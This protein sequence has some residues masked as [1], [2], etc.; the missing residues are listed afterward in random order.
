[1]II[2]GA[3]PVSYISDSKIGVLLIHGFTGNPVS[4]KPIADAFKKAKFNIEMPLLPGHGTKWQD[5]NKIK[6]TDWINRV[7]ISLLELTKRAKYIYIF[8]LSMGSV[9]SEYLAEHH[10][11]IKGL[12]LVN[13]ALILNDPRLFFIPILRFFI[14]STKASGEDIKK[15][16]ISEKSYD[17][18]PTNGVYE[19]TKMQKAIKK[20]LKKIECPVLFFKSRID[21]VTPIKSTLYVYN[22][23]SS[24]EKELVWLD[25]SYHVATLD[26]DKDIIIK[27]SI[28]FIKKFC[29]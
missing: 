18:D 27:K 24:K 20:K 5:L 7:E 12:V 29:I 23:I 11:Y 17:R 16:G 25:N 21:H 22:K 13:D 10:N 4:L 19:L 3:E 26:Y 28:N 1:M 6:Y 14:T 15:P 8:G 9:L 2:K